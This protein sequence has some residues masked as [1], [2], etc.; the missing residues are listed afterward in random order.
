MASEAGFWSVLGN[1]LWVILFGW[2]LAI[3][4]LVAGL[5]L[6]VT[7]IGIPFAIANWK[8]IPLALFPLGREV[9]PID[10]AQTHADQYGPYR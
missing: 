5:L 1:I 3:A 7:I 8:M 9:V 2:E 4:H 10:S 6:F